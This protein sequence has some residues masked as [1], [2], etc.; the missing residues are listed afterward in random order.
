[1][2]DAFFTYHSH[3]LHSFISVDAAL[4]TILLNILLNES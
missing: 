3:A 4:T 2:A 1:M